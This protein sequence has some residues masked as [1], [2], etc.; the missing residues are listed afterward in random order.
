M[1]TPILPV[2][3]LTAISQGQS[4]IRAYREHFG[5]S[6]QDLAVTSGLSVEEIE[7]IETGHRFDKGYRDRIARALGLPE[8]A[9]E[10]VS[11]VQSAA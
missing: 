4:V 9:F 2:A 1:N 3:V 5:Y 6:L 11:D 8:S 7:M 10:E